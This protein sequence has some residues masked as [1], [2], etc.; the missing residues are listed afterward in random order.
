MTLTLCFTDLDSVMSVVEEVTSAAG[1][2]YGVIV[3]I[4]DVM[5]DDGG[6]AVSLSEQ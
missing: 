6:K 1:L 4:D 3:I 5:G 2:Q